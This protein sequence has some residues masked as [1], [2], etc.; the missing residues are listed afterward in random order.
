MTNALPSRGHNREEDSPEALR[1]S[2]ETLAQAIANLN[3][4]LDDATLGLSGEIAEA[5]DTTRR[6]AVEV[7]NMGEALVRRIETAR[8]SNK[9]KR[10][11]RLRCVTLI[12]G[13]MLSLLIL[14]VSILILNVRDILSQSRSREAQ[15]IA[16][17][18]SLPITTANG[19]LRNSLAKA[20]SLM[21]RPPV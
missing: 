15:P 10:T 13:V 14:A 16:W 7:G 21:F 9:M 5:R 17:T 2:V 6:V 12:S 19:C 1:Q 11:V 4:K 18:R 20:T 8:I 3:H